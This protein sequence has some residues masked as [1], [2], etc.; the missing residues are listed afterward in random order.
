M[1]SGRWWPMAPARGGLSDG[2]DGA[3][4]QPVAERRDAPTLDPGA[5]GAGAARLAAS[6]RGAAAWASGWGRCA[7]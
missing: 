7:L 3:E 2:G 6:G 1:A 4:V 5:L